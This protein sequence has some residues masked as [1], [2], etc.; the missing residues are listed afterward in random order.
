MITTMLLGALFGHLWIEQDLEDT[1]EGEVM[2]TSAEW[3]EKH[4]YPQ[5]L[6]P[7]GWDRKNFQ[8]SWN[9]ELITFDEYESR[10]LQSTCMWLASMWTG[11]ADE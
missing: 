2:K 4:P 8:Y 10:L 3:Q 1:L 6:D 9:E 11:D 5:V 7:D